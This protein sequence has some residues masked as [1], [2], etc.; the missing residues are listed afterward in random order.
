MAGAGIA[1]FLPGALIGPRRLNDWEFVLLTAGT[2]VWQIGDE[3]HEC[4]AG[5]ILLVPPAATERWTFG[6][7]GPGRMVFVHFLCRDPRCL[8]LPRRQ[9]PE[10]RAIVE[11]LL[12][13]VLWLRERHLPDWEEQACAA[14]GYLLGA[15]ARQA[16][17]QIEDPLRQFP[18]P[19]QAAMEHLRT[20]W[21]SGLSRITIAELAHAAGVSREHLARSF[22]AAFGMPLAKVLRIVRLERAVHWITVGRVAIPTAA[23]R[24][25]WADQDQFTRAMRAVYGT[26][27]RTLLQRWRQGA[28]VRP[29]NLARGAEFARQL[30]L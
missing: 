29:R 7:E 18:A 26:S 5:D 28:T 12:M 21:R 14:L 4:R 9:S 2:A 11:P 17:G 10:A 13:H 20:R 22:R 3:R 16:L 8:H 25:G 23:R 1:E 30:R 27:P 15:Y 19:V 24:A 6:E